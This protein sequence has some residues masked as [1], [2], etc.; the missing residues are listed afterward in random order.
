MNEQWAN[1]L[2]VVQV[3]IARLTNQLSEIERFYCEGVRLN[4]EYLRV[5]FNYLNNFFRHFNIF[6]ILVR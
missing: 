3:R 1:D 6:L 5:F 2:H 4:T